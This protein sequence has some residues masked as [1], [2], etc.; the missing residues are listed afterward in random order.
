MIRHRASHFGRIVQVRK[1]CTLLRS[2]SAVVIQTHGIRQEGAL[3]CTTPEQLRS[4]L[5]ENLDAQTFVVNTICTLHVDRS[6][7]VLFRSLAAMGKT[8]YLLTYNRD[9]LW[10]VDEIE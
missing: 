8:L 1:P 10:Y 9:R 2:V 7:V 5:L 4:R 6:L 3:T